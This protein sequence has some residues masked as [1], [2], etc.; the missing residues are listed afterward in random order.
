MPARNTLRQTYT[1]FRNAADAEQALL[2]VLESIRGV[3]FLSREHQGTEWLFAKALQ[4]TWSRA[5]RRRKLDSVDTTAEQQ[6]TQPV[7]VC[8]IRS[9]QGARDAP[10][11]TGT[12]EIVL[13]FDWVRGRDRGLF[14]SFMSH[15]ARKLDTLARNLDVEMQ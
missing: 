2:R 11:L 6:P 4:N 10:G 5:A 14:E 15:V 8:R 12:G 7:L 3:S 1:L 9:L 13:E